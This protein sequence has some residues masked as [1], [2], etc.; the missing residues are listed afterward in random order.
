LVS[1]IR[2]LIRLYRGTLFVILMAMLVQ[3]AMSVAAPWPL[4]IV[5][6]NV[7]GSH[8]LAPWIHHILRTGTKIQI[9]IAA[10]LVTILIAIVG[11]MASYF[12]NYYTTSVSQWVAN[13]LRVRTY[14]L[15]QLSLSYYDGHQNRHPLNHHHCRR[16]DDPKFRLIVRAGHCCR[17]VHHRGH[18]GRFVL[19]QLGFRIDRCCCRPFH[20]SHGVEIQESREEG[21][22]RGTKR[23]SRIVTVVEQGL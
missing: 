9:A 13:D 19:A 3:T 18:A 14:H 2:S 4:K 21:D 11:A 1:L 5:L 23:A 20:A 8:K 22:A 12:A 7:V 6:D 15:Q 17:L 16:S 10:A